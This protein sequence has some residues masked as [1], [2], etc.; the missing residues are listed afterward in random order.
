VQRSCLG[1]SCAAGL[2]LFAITRQLHAVVQL[3]FSLL[4]LELHARYTPGGDRSVF[5]VD[6]VASVYKAA[7]RLDTGTTSLACRLLRAASLSRR[8]CKA[9]GGAH[10]LALR[11]TWLLWRTPSGSACDL[12]LT[13]IAVAQ[14]LA[15]KTSVMQPL[16]EDR[17]LCGFSHIF[18]GGYSAGDMS[19][20]PP[21]TV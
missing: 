19:S 1:L 10:P 4:D 13:A 12:A 17:F 6:Q 5:D 7:H 18:A 21:C 20:P 9:S 14:E 16:K 2:E 3:H 15:K 11:V 8:R